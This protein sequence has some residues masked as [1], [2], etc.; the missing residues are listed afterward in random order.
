MACVWSHSGPDYALSLYSARLMRPPCSHQGQH[1]P[2][3]KTVNWTDVAIVPATK[4][5]DE[6]AA[7][8]DMSRLNCS[9][10]MYGTV[11]TLEQLKHEIKTWHSVDPKLDTFAICGKHSKTPFTNGSSC[12]KGA[13]DMC[14]VTPF[15]MCAVT[16]FVMGQTLLD[17]KIAEF[18]ICYLLKDQIAS[19]QFQKESRL[20]FSMCTTDEFQTSNVL[21][22][23][24]CTVASKMLKDD[25]L[26]NTT[27]WK[28]A[29]TACIE[30]KRAFW[31]TLHSSST[32]CDH[33]LASLC[34]PYVL[35]KPW[36]AHC[37]EVCMRSG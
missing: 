12:M 14:A 7:S 5:N 1:H 19:F 23:S 34:K 8:K 31:K 3:C 13:S 36:H 22:S 37:A 4:E 18:D 35:Y 11:A 32:K 16:Q 27:A 15:V 21:V 25:T 9:V 33:V 20:V 28:R 2:Q 10:Q 29:A 30:G 26:C 24:A 17:D 6:C